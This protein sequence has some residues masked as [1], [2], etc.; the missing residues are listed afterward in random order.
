LWDEVPPENQQST[1]DSGI[2]TITVSGAT[3]Q[4]F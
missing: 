3:Q 2:V 4:N 1:V